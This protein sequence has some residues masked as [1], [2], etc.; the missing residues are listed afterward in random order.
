MNQCQVEATFSVTVNTVTEIAYKRVEALFQ[1][2][3]PSAGRP[4]GPKDSLD[5]ATK[6]KISRALNQTPMFVQSLV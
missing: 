3:L 6:R 4:M 1:S 5:M 2:F